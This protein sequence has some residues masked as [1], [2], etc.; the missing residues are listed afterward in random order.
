VDRPRGFPRNLTMALVLFGVAVLVL[1]AGEIALLADRGFQAPFGVAVL[2]PLLAWLQIATG[3]FA[4]VRRPANRIGPLLCAGGL[5]Y[6]VAA[7]YLIDIPFFYSI[8]TALRSAPLAVLVHTLL[9]F[10]SGRLRST[11]SRVLAVAIYV[12]ALVLQVPTYLFRP[13]FPGEP[14]V[15]RIADRPDLTNLAV[16]VENT[17]AGLVLAAIAVV[18][19]RRLVIAD[20]PLRRVLLPVYGCGAVVL[21]V[22]SSG[23]NLL[24]AV[25]VDGLATFDIF[26]TL[27]LAVMRSRS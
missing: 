21:V 17:I 1:G 20:R 4:W 19:I 25:G 6:F 10:P 3:L 18:L 23:V 11:V 2:W 22:A 14:D 26:W 27:V 13:L 9:C 12:V 15:L 5:L 16:H 24:T 7:A 8:G